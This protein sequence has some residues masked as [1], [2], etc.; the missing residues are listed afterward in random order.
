MRPLMLTMRAFGSYGGE[1]AIDFS[2]TNQ[3]LFLITGD[4][5]A[6][7][8]TIFDAIVF[9]LYGQTGSFYN[10][11]EG[12][13]LQSHFTSYDNT[14]QVTFRFAKSAQEGAPVY[15]VRRVPKHLRPAKRRGS[16]GKDFIEE[17]GSV[18]LIL[19]DKSVYAERNVDE[20]IEEIVGLTREQFM[21]VAMIAQGEFM[22]LLRA[23]TDDKKEIFR[24]L[25]NTELY[26]RIRYILE[27]RKKAKEREIAVIR[28][29]CRNEI[30]H[31]AVT[32]DFEKYSEIEALAADIRNEKLT[33]LGAYMELLE[34]Y[35]AAVRNQISLLAAE[36]G[37]VRKALEAAQ[38]DYAKAKTLIDAF[39][40]YDRAQA[41]LA[42]CG[43]LEKEMQEKERLAVLL[44]EAYE[45][46][47]VYQLYQEAERELN[48][49]RQKLSDQEAVLPALE[50]NCAR[51]AASCE[52]VS[53]RYE[54]GKKKLHEISQ[55][56][57]E[58]ARLFDRR[59]RIGREKAEKTA[60]RQSV[61]KKRD[62]LEAQLADMKRTLDKCAEEL[63]GYND[64]YAALAEAEHALEKS[65][66]IRE[67]IDALL[68][69]QRDIDTWNAKLRKS[70]KEFQK[71]EAAY[72]QKRDHYE[73]ANRL[74]LNEQAGILAGALVDGE[75]CRV[76]GSR[77]HP[78][79]Y[80]LPEDFQVPTQGDVEAARKACEDWNQRQ[81]Q[82]SLEANEMRTTLENKF[83]QYTAECGKIGAELGTQESDTDVILK[84]YE[85]FHSG[86]SG[87]RQRCR[88]RMDYL[89]A[90][91][92]EQEKGIK[93]MEKLQGRL[94]Q[95]NARI[96]ALGQEL[97]GLEAAWKELA[98]NT[99]FATR[100]D[101]DLARKQAEDDF[102]LLQE[103]YTRADRENRKA[104]REKEK[105][106]SLIGE[107]RNAVPSRQARAG[108][109][110]SEYEA[111]L[112]RRSAE[113][114]SGWQ[115]LTELYSRQ[116]LSEWQGQIK[117]HHEKEQAAKAQA[118]TAEEIIRDSQKPDIGRMQQDIEDLNVRSEAVSSAFNEKTR[119][120][121]TD[122]KVLLS[123]Q[124]QMQQR[125]RTI[126]EHARLDALYR[127]VSGTVSRQN[128][129]DLETF[130]Q[131]YYLRQILAAANRRFEKMTAG[132]FQLM[133]KDTEEAGRVKNE[134]L[135]LMVYSLVTGKK[136]E[137]RT[138]SGG[139]S[140]MAAL[141]LAL[142]MADQI[143]GGSGAVSLDMMFIDEGF[144]S[145]DEH[146]RSQAVRILKEMAGGDRM[147]GII[148]HVT[149]LKQEI[150]SQL[151]VTKDETGSS[152]EWRMG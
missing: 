21:Q 41:V 115:R 149:E 101:A 75:P 79:P 108:Q 80:R 86:V 8:T 88:E 16:S 144:G 10:K 69:M 89:E 14:P 84:A 145:L 133:L 51:A 96:T 35:C 68:E 152:V 140:F 60:E 114:A 39:A 103:E 59:D 132:Q 151:V 22:E 37:D 62:R 1:T 122:E 33:C 91:G 31:V 85:T 87:T 139:E 13:L 53:A 94:D 32:D 7:K 146:S 30:T 119:I 92:A 20:K 44:G 48:D 142:G 105:A 117:A 98:N 71:A 63:K 25:F 57:A 34:A 113:C 127:I 50:E 45:I 24:K 73:Q 141:S 66:V 123:L 9:A 2:R 43:A 111:L 99:G 93:N 121:D 58:A 129:M 3:N 36:R 106:L 4:T 76:C 135:D 124:S 54:D 143:K 82:K 49:V 138:L 67:R 23:K 125:E 134:G 77:V 116:T 137:V 78:Q 120:C 104:Q 64:A 90:Q 110:K 81:Q 52:E 55:K 28:T 136:R 12:V 72:H 46:R 18:E 38:A 65:A 112:Q 131:R 150:D 27:D 26:E 29:T 118:A 95:V 17:K 61:E 83:A 147:I 109:Q 56:A 130:V 11:K 126:R 6:G 5:G 42:E 148:S 97:S 70:Q 102:A 19:P 15:T 128:K 74:F 47:P 40:A 100:D 107:Y